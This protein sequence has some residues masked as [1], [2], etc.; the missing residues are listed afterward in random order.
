MHAINQ[1]EE[2]EH[3]LEE[4]YNEIGECRE[5]ERNMH[6]QFVQ[7][8]ATAGTMLALI[9]GASSFTD[10]PKN[11]LYHLSN[12]VLCIAIAYIAYQ[13]I[14][15]SLRY[16]HLQNL[17]DRLSKLVSPN[18]AESE[19]LVHWMSLSS[20]LVT[21]NFKHIVSKHSRYTVTEYIFFTITVLCLMVFCII[22][23]FIQFFSLEYYNFIDIM[24]FCFL[25][26]FGIFIIVS[27]F[28]LTNHAKEIYQFSVSSASQQRNDRV[29]MKIFEWVRTNKLSR[30]TDCENNLNNKNDSVHTNK[31]K[32]CGAGTRTAAF[33]KVVSYYCYPRKADLQ[34]PILI[35]FG[36]ISGCLFSG[37]LFI[38]PFPLLKMLF[39]LLVL[40]ILVYQARF[41]WNDLRGMMQDLYANKEGRLPANIIGKKKSV[42]I[43]LVTICIKNSAA[44][45]L[46]GFFGGEMTFPLVFHIIL[47]IAVSL[48]YESARQ[49]KK[50]VFVFILVCVGYPLRFFAGFWSSFPEIVGIDF[51]ALF[52]DIS[53]RIA[54]FWT[55]NIALTRSIN[56]LFFVLLVISIA[57]WGESCVI[58]SWTHE[59]LAGKYSNEK[60]HIAMLHKRV[61]RSDEPSP[62][63]LSENGNIFKPWNLT[64]VVSFLPLVIG[65]FFNPY[66]QL[67]LIILESL[68]F[69]LII[70]SLSW[71]N[72]MILCIFIIIV[73]QIG[74][75]FL[76]SSCLIYLYICFIQIIY[77]AVYYFLRY[78]Y[79][80]DFSFILFIRDFANFVL[81]W[82]VGSETFNAIA[83]EQSQ[84]PSFS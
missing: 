18:R 56:P 63:S 54:F 29:S 74:A 27:F 79:L 44:F 60:T 71:K 34:K 65:Q 9:F 62:L 7:V 75:L 33:F 15:G 68:F 23:V 20:S 57:F 55:E 1:L 69:G 13:A 45:I 10:A 61:S 35:V 52:S 5:D 25:I 14:L 30:D 53:T 78:Y 3:L 36:F 26:I 37:E 4:L 24:A 19:K 76:L 80:V 40:D 50:A 67:Y 64:F 32:N 6:N 22:L 11:I 81:K 38:K 48:F 84:T 70:L 42:I 72:G 41:Q 58:L 12:L 39:V 66:N 77:I 2:N 16:Y 17:E 31:S 46:I 51:Y 43:S 49:R 21:K 59:A 73:K 82:V 83:E 47:I 8:I 28:Y